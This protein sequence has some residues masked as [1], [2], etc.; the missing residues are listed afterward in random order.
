MSFASLDRRR[1][2]MQ[3]A[4]GSAALGLGLNTQRAFASETTIGVVYVGPRDDFGWNRSHQESLDRAQRQSRGR[5]ER[6][7]DDCRRKVEGID[8]YP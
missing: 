1:F 3:S 2:M 5:G 4:L 6:A 8:D 7:G